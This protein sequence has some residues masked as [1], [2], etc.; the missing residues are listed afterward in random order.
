[1]Q[2]LKKRQTPWKI[3]FNTNGNRLEAYPTLSLGV[4][5]CSRPSRKERLFYLLHGVPETIVE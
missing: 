2:Q 3:D 4:G 5:A 1:V